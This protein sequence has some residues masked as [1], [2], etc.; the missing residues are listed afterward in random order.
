MQMLGINSRAETIKKTNAAIKRHQYASNE[1]SNKGKTTG[2]SGGKMKEIR[3]IKSSSN[4][5]TVNTSTV[6]GKHPR[7][8]AAIITCSTTT[9]KDKGGFQNTKQLV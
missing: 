1:K 7:Q 3:Q 6:L 2:S 5:N 9:K 4:V 8:N